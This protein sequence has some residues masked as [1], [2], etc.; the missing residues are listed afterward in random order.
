MVTGTLNCEFHQLPYAKKV[1][2]KTAALKWNV[3]LQ[4]RDETVFFDC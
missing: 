2:G 1:A 4:G 3:I